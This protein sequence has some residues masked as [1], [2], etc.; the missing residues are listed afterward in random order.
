MSLHRE[1]GFLNEPKAIWTL[2]DPGHDINGN[3]VPAHGRFRLDPA[4]VDSARRL[5]AKRLFS[6]YLALTG[7][8]RLVDKYPELIFRV[9]Y[10]KQLFPDAIIIFI[11]R[12]GVDA[13]QSIVKWSQRLG[14]ATTE[15]TDD[16]WGR[17]DIKWHYFREQLVL[18]DPQYS[19]IH[20]LAVPGLDHANRAAM[21]WVVTMREGL[22]Q[23]RRHPDMIMIRYEDLLAQPEQELARLFEACGLAPDDAVE[24]YAKRTLYENS[25]KTWPNIDS[26][27][28]K[29]FRE[30]MADLGYGIN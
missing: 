23:S 10:L 8:K 12:N 9:D 22:A 17:D 21:E 11:A 3:Y 29:I 30:T 18:A 20:H 13:A 27:L 4:H 15:H 26:E 14:V 16:W 19:S 24:D 28:D 6:R 5:T 1:V 2:I 7:G 25:S